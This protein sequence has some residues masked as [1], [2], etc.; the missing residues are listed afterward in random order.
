MNC[1]WLNF[2]KNPSGVEKSIKM[3]LNITLNNLILN[4]MIDKNIESQ[5]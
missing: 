5:R 1:N 4:T 3:Q 2:F